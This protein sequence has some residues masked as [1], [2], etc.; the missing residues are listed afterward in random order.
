V[1]QDPCVDEWSLTGYTPLRE[2]GRGGFGR[3]VLARHEDSGTHVAIKYLTVTDAAFRAEFRAE[4][5]ILHGLDDPYVVRLYEY[6]DGPR[7]SA[8]VMEAIDGVSLR[9]LLKEH[10]SLEPEA[11][12]TVLKG[13]LLGLG[14]A[15]RAGVVH[16]DYKPA[17]VMVDGDGRSKLID[18]GIALRSGASGQVIGTPA[19]MSPE[20]WAGSPASP[21]TDVYAATCVFFEC[22][23]GRTPYRATTSDAYRA[24]HTTAPIPVEEAPEQVRA[25]IDRGLAKDPQGRPLGALEFAAELE[26]A[27]TEAYGPAWESNGRRRLAETAAGL[28][29][30]FPLALLVSHTAPGA[31]AAGGAAAGH[32]G[33]AAA[34][35]AGGAAAG[36]AGGAAAGKAAAATGRGALTKILG[37]N[38]VVKTAAVATGAVVVGSATVAAVVVSRHHAPKKPAAVVRVELASYTRPI[39][40][41]D[42]RNSRYARVTGVQDAAVARKINA[43]LSGP[44]DWAIGVLKY[45]T[46][47]ASP[48][49]TRPTGL[50][51]RPELGLR[52]PRFVSVRYELPKRPCFQ[53]DYELPKVVANVDLRTGKALT[54][55]DVFLPQTL[56]PGG[57]ATLMKRVTAHST[58]R[59]TQQR[60]ALEPLSRADFEPGEPFDVGPQPPRIT[61]FFTSKGMDVQWSH[62]GSDCVFYAVT[63]P[64]TEVRDLLDPRIVAELPR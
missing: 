19:Y 57:F 29:A 34:G 47:H 54:A 56:T 25:L 43:S 40:G 15:H 46:A 1:Q 38:T 36:H 9:E 39:A 10:G 4:A 14:A 58:D 41:L 11:A 51:A 42:L 64:Y 17:N 48:P 35:H 59:L 5:A 55:D 3:V 7:G 26:S 12:L 37:A 2:L 45:Q 32:A 6:A 62:V 44:L 53:L 28:A 49:C 52:G 24:Q 21:S 33:G 50:D 63:L 31:A 22:V 16:R 30:L 8:I 20:Q 18:F 23:T 27:A 13:S 60:C 61:P